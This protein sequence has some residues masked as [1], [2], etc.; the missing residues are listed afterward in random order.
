MQH[1]QSITFLEY[2]NT[3]IMT[4]A[5]RLFWVVGKL[6]SRLPLGPSL[7]S[8]KLPG[9][10]LSDDGPLYYVLL[11]MYAGNRVL[12]SG[13]GVMTIDSMT[14]RPTAINF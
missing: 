13:R 6:E 7:R 12:Y 1:H 8:E 11:S 2:P 10:P 4:R 14:I 9:R 5:R 3:Y